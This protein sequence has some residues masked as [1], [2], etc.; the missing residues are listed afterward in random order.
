MFGQNFGSYFQSPSNMQEPDGSAQQTFQP[1]NNGSGAGDSRDNNIDKTKLIVNYIPQFTTEQ[2]LAPIFLKIGPI[3]N[4]RIMRDFKTGYSFGFGFVKYTTPEHAAQAIEKINGMTFKDKRL[5]VSI[6]RPPGQEMKN[7]NLYITNLPKDITEQE[8]DE[9]FGQY[10]EIVQRT[11]LKDKITGMPRGVAFVRYS[12]GEE[13]QSAIANLDG[14]LLENGYLPLKIRVAEDHGRQK[15]QFYYDYMSQCM[16]NRGMNI[17]PFR[18]NTMCFRNM[19]LTR[20][21]MPPLRGNRQLNTL[22]PNR[23]MSMGA[24]DNIFQNPMFW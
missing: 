13:A 19:Q 7:S 16:F 9:L 14:K 18:S 5:K 3:E 20:S 22:G 6:S 17:N 8:I 2:E 24:G 4:I 21:S 1:N 12:K 10:G 23:F 15:A 11:I